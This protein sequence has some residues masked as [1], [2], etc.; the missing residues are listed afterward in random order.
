MAKQCILVPSEAYLLP[1]VCITIFLGAVLPDLGDGSDDAG[2]NEA[3]PW[4]V[5]VILAC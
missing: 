1:V 2:V 4:L 3:E 5:L